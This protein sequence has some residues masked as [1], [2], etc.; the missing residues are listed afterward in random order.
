[1]IDASCQQISATNCLSYIDSNTCGTCPLQYLF[2]DASN[3][4][5]KNPDVTNCTVY[6]T[7]TVC[8][9]CETG[10]YV[11]AGLCV[12][13][14]T[15]TANCTSYD[16]SQICNACQS[17]FYLFNGVC[18][19]NPS[20]DTNCSQFD[21]SSTQCA[22]CAD[23]FV[24]IAGVCVKCGPDFS[25]CSICSATNPSKCLV[26]RTGHYMNLTG[27]CVQNSKIVGATPVIRILT[28]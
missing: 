8:A 4:C 9:Q 19:A 21:F 5:G 16:S 1:M 24:L 2:L 3:Y 6:Q 28:G 15:L 25:K 13:V 12:N 10:F 20:W 11:S 17:G 23:G 22:I 26:C 18:I 27:D 7:P 14:T